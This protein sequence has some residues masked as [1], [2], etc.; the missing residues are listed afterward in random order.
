[1]PPETTATEAEIARLKL[2]ERLRQHVL[3]LW[4]R[5]REHPFVVALGNGLLPRANFE[6]YIRQDA[7]FLDELTKT[8]AYAVTKTTD[9]DEMEQFGK[10]VLNTLLV[11]AE[12]HR[13]YRNPSPTPHRY[14]PLRLDLCRDWSS[15][16]W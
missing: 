11:E 1:M 15:S 7:L 12:L 3:P 4:Q 14:P 13:R 6:F 16:R 8:F 9:H 2:S 10:Y 5:Q